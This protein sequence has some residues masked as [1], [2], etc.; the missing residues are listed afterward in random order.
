MSSSSRLGGLPYHPNQADEKPSKCNS[1]RLSQLDSLPKI[2]KLQIQMM[3]IG[4]ENKDLIKYGELEN[5]I[6]TRNMTPSTRHLDEEQ[7]H[8]EPVHQNR[9]LKRETSFE[10]LEQ[11]E[12]LSQIMKL[13]RQHQKQGQRKT[14]N[15]SSHVF[16]AET[17]HLT[18]QS[19]NMM[20]LIESHKQALDKN[21]QLC[22]TLRNRVLLSSSMLN[23]VNNLHDLEQSIGYVKPEF[24]FLKSASRTRH[25][26]MKI[27]DMTSKTY[28]EMPKLDTPKLETSDLLGSQ[29]CLDYLKNPNFGRPDVKRSQNFKI[30]KR[31]PAWK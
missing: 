28:D 6:E 11:I 29:P 18:R 19:D 25:E 15:R 16:P 17:V 3:K 12:K 13:K 9:N 24:K 4:S 14:K 1:G 7:K 31:E 27:E 22:K 2:Q 23:H 30:L 20:R 26:K 10:V 21:R 5:I 8:Y